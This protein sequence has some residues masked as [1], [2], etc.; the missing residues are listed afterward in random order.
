M[1]LWIMAQDRE[2]LVNVKELH[3]KKYAPDLCLA[4]EKPKT[5]YDIHSENDK[6]LATYKDIEQAK[7]VLAEVEKEIM[8]RE[9][10][11]T[12]RPILFQMP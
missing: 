4:N 1:K 6:W 10:D 11:G 7:I 3:I 12:D 2:S 9:L 5:S 8:E